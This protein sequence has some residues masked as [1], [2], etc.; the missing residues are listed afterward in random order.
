MNAT[1]Q[2]VDLLGAAAL[3]IW[4][5]RMIKTGV[6]RA[7]GAVLRQW[8]AKGTTN[9][10]SAAFWGFIVTLG[11]QSSTA[12]A[13]ITASFTARD[14][15]TPRMAQAVLLGANLGTAIVTL[16]L[17]MDL[18]WLGSLLIL[19][20]VV[21]STSAQANTPRN[22]GRAILGL[23][24]M[25]LALHL[26]G[27]V[28]APLRSSPTLA[29]VLSALDTAPVL[30]VLIAAGLAVLAS[31]SLAVVVLVM[32]LAGAGVVDGP[33]ALCLVAGANLGGA[34]PPH[35]AVASDG[36]AARRLTLSNMIVRMFGSVLVMLFAAPLAAE[37][38]QFLPDPAHLTVA[39][40]VGFNLALLLIF[41]PLLGPVAKLTEQLLPARTDPAGRGPTY[42]DDSL[43]Q[44]PDM[45]LA[46][47]ARE[48]LRLGDII[49]DMLDCTLLSLKTGDEK[50]I[51]DVARLEDEVDFL[52]EAIKLYVT[53][54]GRSELDADDSRRANE[55]ISYAINL[56][57]VGD[58][59][60]SGLAEIAVK[61]ARKKLTFSTEGLAEIADFYGH[62]RENLRMA[63]AIFL[64]RDPAMARRLLD[65][66]VIIRKI[67][68]QS[69][70]RHLNRVREGRV[71]T[72]ETST[73]HLDLLRDLKRVNAHLAS[74]AH[75]ILEELGVLR[76]SRVRDVI[77][78]V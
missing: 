40:H 18:H 47:A 61:K 35:L 76:E 60:E 16:F 44:T 5:L 36:V 7:F 75:P 13:V 78:P 24:L 29:M 39:A 68:A 56:E 55:V 19:A 73:L 46:V 26:L 59:I 15:V 77:V 74:V 34:I 4:G 14:I 20:G 70:E 45:A 71:E 23:G 63:Q 62:T 2:L 64:S 57:H 38:G 31:S 32:L 50:P 22:S 66:K 8:I 9:R 28:T 65:Q 53:R 10:V 67:E 37:L 27:G 69:S 25:L 49:G 11:L 48:A 1:I 21:L 72:I 52:H 30:A 43:L 58:I 51:A 6:L 42:L 17:S 12:T 3:L 54:L 41:L 33:L